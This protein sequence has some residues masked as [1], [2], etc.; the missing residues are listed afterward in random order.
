[1]LVAADSGAAEAKESQPLCVVLLYFI[2]ERMAAKAVDSM[3]RASEFIARLGDQQF[4]AFVARE[5]LA[6]EHFSFERLKTLK[7]RLLEDCL[8]IFRTRLQLCSPLAR[9]H[10]YALVQAVCGAAGAPRLESLAGGEGFSASLS[11]S[12]SRSPL[13][14]RAHRVAWADQELQLVLLA[15]QLAHPSDQ[16]LQVVAE[17]L[18]YFLQAGFDA[19]SAHLADAVGQLL[20]QSGFSFLQGPGGGKAAGG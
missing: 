6:N 3:E 7:A 14:P 12:F 20:G 11:K 19:G 13:S 10:F 5:P 16:A 4:Q 8:A 1:M 18:R 17:N 9:T 2:R 15:W